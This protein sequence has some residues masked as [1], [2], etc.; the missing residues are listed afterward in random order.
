MFN[1][2]T[3]LAT[4]SHFTPFGL[5]RTITV[6]RSK[7]SPTSIYAIFELSIRLAPIYSADIHSVD[8]SLLK[9]RGSFTKMAKRRTLF[10]CL[11]AGFKGQIV[12]SDCANWQK[13]FFEIRGVWGL[14][15]RWV[16]F[17]IGGVTMRK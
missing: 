16:N 12:D 4:I 10:F 6:A 17:V 13:S 14:A 9:W 2:L 3:R 7:R 15:M 1:C 11:T 5:S 8:L